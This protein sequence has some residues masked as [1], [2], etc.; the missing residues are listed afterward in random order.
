LKPLPFA[1]KI[2]EFALKGRVRNEDS[3][4][5]QTNLRKLQDRPPAA[6]ALRHLLHQSQAQA[7]ARLTR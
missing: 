5:R 6:Q 1:G 7:K 2:G 4:Q 3:I